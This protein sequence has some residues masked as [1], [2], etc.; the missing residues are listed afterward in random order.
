M[1]SKQYL[2]TIKNRMI[3]HVKAAGQIDTVLIYRYIEYIILEQICYY[4][5]D[6]VSLPSCHS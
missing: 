3:L 4:S 6:N 5:D 1:D 2:D